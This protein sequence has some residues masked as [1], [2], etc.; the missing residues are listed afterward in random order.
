MARA[1]LEVLGQG[2]GWSL[3][4]LV[5]RLG[6]DGYPSPAIAEQLTALMWCGWISNDTLE[7]VR[8]L[9]GARGTRRRHAPAA[10][11]GPVR[12]PRGR[13]ADLSRPRGQLGSGSPGH[14]VATSPA[15]GAP[16]P[17]TLVGR[18][19]ALIP[20]EVPPRSPRSPGRTRNS[21]AT[22]W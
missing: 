14:D 9:R 19:F 2:G 21:T 13:Y 20:D 12:P 1:I 7:P 10:R 5:R 4:D 15:R 16:G 8:L 22:A 17:A 11:R 6:S 18:W 3:A